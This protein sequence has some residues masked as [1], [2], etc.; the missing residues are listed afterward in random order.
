MQ[1][2]SNEQDAEQVNTEFRS[3]ILR[4][5]LQG[6]K[7]VDSRTVVAVQRK[8]LLLQAEK[9]R[10]SDLSPELVRDVQHPDRVAAPPGPLL[11]Y[12]VRAEPPEHAVIPITELLLSTSPEIRAAALEYLDLWKVLDQFQLTPNTAKNIDDFRGKL[13]D[14]KD[15]RE[16][17]LAISDALT[18]DILAN[19][20]GLRQSL[21]MNF[22]AGADQYGAIVLRPTISSLDSIDLRYWQ[23]S[24]QRSQIKDEIHALAEMSSASALFREYYS[25][26][27][28]LPLDRSL[29][30]AVALDELES[31]Q[32]A[33]GSIWHEIWEAAKA[34]DSPYARYHACL[35]FLERPDLIPPDAREAI[36]TEIV[37]IVTASNLA[38]ESTESAKWVPRL[39]L[40]QH[41][42]NYL[43]CYLPGSS[44]ERLA[45]FSWWIAD[46]VAQVFLSGGELTDSLSERLMDPIFR[47]SEATRKLT[48]PRLEPSRLA[49]STANF[50]NPWSFALQ[51]QVPGNAGP[52]IGKLMLPQA[53]SEQ[54]PTAQSATDG[55]QDLFAGDRVGKQI[56]GSAMSLFWF[57]LPE[58]SEPVFVRV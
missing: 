56:S 43:A 25:K 32:T 21:A 10:F 28:H 30:V 53:T 11:F 31:R 49:H 24:A 17:A 5:V 26:F 33:P 8:G 42:Y 46:L 13:I 48:N 23:P 47:A 14:E 6:Q 45:V 3:R 55:D 7:E 4:V 40:A 18:D 50:K 44:S 34:I 16:G 41:Y 37:E 20:A 39:T 27:G 12:V 29:S 38:E 54:T 35:L 36:W 1:P 51:C 15:W 9:V 52:E 57:P 19:L 22:E 2:K 58:M